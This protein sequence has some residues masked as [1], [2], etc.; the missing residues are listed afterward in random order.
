MGR[1]RGHKISVKWE[2]HPGADLG[3]KYGLRPREMAWFLIGKKDVR[4]AV[5]SELASMLGLKLRKKERK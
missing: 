2:S 4:L 5:A 1:R 3:R